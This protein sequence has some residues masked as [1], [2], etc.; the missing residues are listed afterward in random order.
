METI[1]T[2]FY[3]PILPLKTG[4]IV[5]ILFLFYRWL[6]LVISVCKKWIRALFGNIFVVSI[7]IMI[8][9]I[10]DPYLKVKNEE[11]GRLSN[12]VSVTHMSSS[13]FET[14]LE[15]LS[16][17]SRRSTHTLNCSSDLPSQ[18]CIVSRRWSWNS[19]P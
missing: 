4:S 13:S 2:C 17:E 16:C 5:S 15:R 14:N 8:I 7:F 6:I 12:L 3:Y 11:L 18:C 19:Y 9:I 10:T 1:S